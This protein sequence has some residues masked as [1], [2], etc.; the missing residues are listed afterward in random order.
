MIDKYSLGR[1][2]HLFFRILDHFLS[3]LTSPPST[4]QSKMSYAGGDGQA[5]H[6][7]PSTL[8]NTAKVNQVIGTSP[9]VDG[10]EH[11]T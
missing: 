6:S 9:A 2:R 7:R 1:E 3:L 4:E 10:N 8:T 5:S 11:L